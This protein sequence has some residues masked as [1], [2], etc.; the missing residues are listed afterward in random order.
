MICLSKEIINIEI[1]EESEFNVSHFFVDNEYLSIY[2]DYWVYDN[3]K[4]ESQFVIEANIIY[5][6]FKDWIFK[7]YYK[8]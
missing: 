1:F 7:N 8:K 3:L 6:S 4:M 2:D 5:E